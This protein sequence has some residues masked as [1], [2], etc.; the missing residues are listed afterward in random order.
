MGD[1]HDEQKEARAGAGH[2]G[3]KRAPHAVPLVP[4][5]RNS[6]TVKGPEFDMPGPW[7][8]SEF[9]R[10]PWRV[11]RVTIYQGDLQNCPFPRKQGER[12]YVLNPTNPSLSHGSGVARALR[13]RF[14]ALTDRFTQEQRQNNQLPFHTPSAHLQINRE[15]G[16]TGIVHCC[17][18]PRQRQQ[19]TEDQQ[20]ILE[21]V[22]GLGIQT[23][24]GTPPQSDLSYRY[25]VVKSFSMNRTPLPWRSIN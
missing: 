11:G 3:P 15:H 6:L 9:I 13:D 4:S 2:G 1:D 21:E 16:L 18:L 17:Y 20:I 12:V 19:T 14:P 22:M 24:W 8:P 23:I 7:V 25:S 10:G 5:Q